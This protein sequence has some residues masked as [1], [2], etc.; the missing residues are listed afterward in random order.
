MQMSAELQAKMIQWRSK[1]NEGTISEAEITEAMEALR[2]ERKAAAVATKSKTA[3]AKAA[4]PSAN[5]LLGEIEGMD[6]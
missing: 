3:K 2:G 4:I 1:C 5:E 6:E